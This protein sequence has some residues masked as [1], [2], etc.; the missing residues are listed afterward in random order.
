MSE[1]VFLV[2]VASLIFS[3]AAVVYTALGR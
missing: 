2:I 1:L 3:A